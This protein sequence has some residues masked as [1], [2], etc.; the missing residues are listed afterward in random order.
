MSKIGCTCGGTISDTT[1]HLPYKGY[2]T[3]DTIYFDQI[4]HATDDV[5]AFLLA[6]ETGSE[7]Q[8]L[9]TYFGARYSAL[10]LT[11]ENIIHDIFARHLFRGQLTVYQCPA[12]RRLLIQQ[13]DQSNYFHGFTPEDTPKPDVFASSNVA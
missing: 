7:K 1:D 12:C 10:Q 5:A 6:R 8:W 2:L 9:S 13:N 3:S 11:P 4:D